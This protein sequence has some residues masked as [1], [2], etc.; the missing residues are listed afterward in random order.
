MTSRRTAAPTRPTGRDE[1]RAA[2]LDSAARHFAA[3]GT[4]ASLRDIA[5]DAGVNLGLIHRHF[6]NKDD[7]LAAVLTS[8]GEAGREVVEQA[9]DLGEAVA[10]IFD[11]L[12]AGDTYISTLA[13]LLL[14]R[15]DVS[16][17]QRT[18]PTI[19]ALRARAADDD[20]VL[21]L[22]AAFALMYGWQVFGDQLVRSFGVRVK[23]RPRAERRVS[24]LLRDLVG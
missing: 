11:A 18:F 20:Q 10:G 12:R 4:H 17:Y 13:W 3:H 9:A 2:I 7:L 21:R 19:D 16:R 15:E 8:R 22:V 23:D 1:V 24:E 14:A 6:G 5:A